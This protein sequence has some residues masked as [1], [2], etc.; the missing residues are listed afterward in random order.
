LAREV[1]QALQNLSERRSNAGKSGIP[2]V[3]REGL[4]SLTSVA[5]GA[6]EG[7]LKSR[8]LDGELKQA[9]ILAAYGEARER[10]ANAEKL[11]AE[12]ELARIAV[13]RARLEAALDACKAF[14]VDPVVALSA[15]NA[16]ALVLGL[17]LAEERDSSSAPTQLTAGAEPTGDV[18]EGEGV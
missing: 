16:P 7:T 18:D 17:G 13:A 5:V 15:S 8:S 11:E 10:N 1:A 6:V 14:G 9:Q 2:D 12:A 4:P 3:V